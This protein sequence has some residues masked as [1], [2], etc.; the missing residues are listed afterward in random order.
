MA[1]TNL[2]LPTLASADAAS[3][4]PATFN[5]AMGKIDAAH[6]HSGADLT[7]SIESAESGTGASLYATVDGNVCTLFLGTISKAHAEANQIA[8]LP[9][10]YRPKY[11]VYAVGMVASTPCMMRIA[12][13]GKIVIWI[14]GNSV[15][16]NLRM[17]CTYV[18]A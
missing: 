9:E 8:V 11:L 1:T 5:D 4:F 2:N 13:D 18:L 10:G 12:T 3:N 17:G 16:G 15:T 14:M 7:S 6:A